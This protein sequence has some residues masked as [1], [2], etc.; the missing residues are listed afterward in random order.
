M[1]HLKSIQEFDYSKYISVYHRFIQ[2][3]SVYSQH[4]LGGFRPHNSRISYSEEKK[5]MSNID[6]QISQNSSL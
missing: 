1:I 3:K 5:I 4:Y 2:S 6:F